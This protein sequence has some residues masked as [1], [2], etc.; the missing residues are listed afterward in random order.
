MISNVSRIGSL[1]DFLIYAI[2]K[3]MYASVLISNSFTS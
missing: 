2:G 1:Y 3:Y